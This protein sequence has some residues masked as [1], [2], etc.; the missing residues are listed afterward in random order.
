MTQS[1]NYYPLVSYLVDQLGGRAFVTQYANDLAGPVGTASS[2]WGS[3]YPDEDDWLGELALRHTELTRLYTRVSGWEMI[4]D[5][6]FEP[7]PGGA[8]GNTLDLSDN[9][10]VEVCQEVVEAPCGSTYCGEGATCATTELGDGCLCPVGTVARRIQSPELNGLSLFPTV[11]CQR[12]DFDMMASLSEIPGIGSLNPCA[13]MDCGT[14]GECVVINGF[15]ACECDDGLAAVANAT[16]MLCLPV[17]DTFSP[18]D[19][20]LAPRAEAEVA[21]RSS[22]SAGM[23]LALVLLVVPAAMLRLRRRPPG[24]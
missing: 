8:I 12:L 13:E 24:C 21:E 16:G 9:Q 23:A 10:P 17:L 7:S 5:P 2:R 4:S 6:F 11:A 20:L 22:G 18:E 19:A 3:Q 14:G 15:G 1:T